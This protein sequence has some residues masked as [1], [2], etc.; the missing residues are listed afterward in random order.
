MSAKVAGPSEFEKG[1]IVMARRL[2]SWLEIYANLQSTKT[3]KSI[4]RDKV[5]YKS[6]TH[7]AQRILLDIP[8]HSR[9]P[10][11]GP[12]LTKLHCQLHLE[13]APKH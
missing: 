6:V 13:W 5:P 8:V 7:T 2:G 1:Q 9:R 10:T 12:P 4:I 11:R 3:S